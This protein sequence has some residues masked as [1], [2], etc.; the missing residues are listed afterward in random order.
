MILATK[1]G[2][3]GISLSGGQKQRLALARAVYACN[4]V[5]M[6]D[7]IFSGLDA[8]TEEHVFKALFARNG[9]FRKLHTTVILATHAVHRLSYADHIVA[10]DSDGSVAEQ[11][12]LEELKANGGYVALLK[13]QYKEQANDGRDPQQK[14]TTS[15]LVGADQGNPIDDTAEELARGNGDFALYS[16]YFGSV[17]WA[18]S[19]LWMTLLVLEGSLPK[20][21]ELVVKYWVSALDKNGSS[22]NSFYLGIYASVSIIAVFALVGGAYHLIVFFSP[23]SAKTLHE[24]LLR[25]VMHAP[26][27]FF[28]SVDTGTTM[29][30]CVILDP[31]RKEKRKS[32]FTNIFNF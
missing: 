18:S 32:K 26:L 27:S 22:V 4:D 5:I 11:G 9:L 25:S 14:D 10:L 6:L 24:R 1:V 8:D 3:S 23:R 20:L 7:D 28:T 16:Y 30:R 13:A 17:H 19:L 31:E 21:S 12:T 29:N 2:S 15:V